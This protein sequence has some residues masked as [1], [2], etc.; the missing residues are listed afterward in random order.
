VYLKYIVTRKF[1]SYII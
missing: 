1:L